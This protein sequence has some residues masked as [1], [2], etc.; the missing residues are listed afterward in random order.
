MNKAPIAPVTVDGENELRIS[1][2]IGDRDVWARIWLVRVGRTRLYLLD[3]D[4][5]GMI[6]GIGNCPPGFIP[7][8]RKCACGRRSCSALAACA[9]CG[10]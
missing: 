5:D 4:V 6:P 2:R 8:T 7:V 10:R 3:S 9:R 1:V